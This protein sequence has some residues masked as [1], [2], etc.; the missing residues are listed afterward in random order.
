M[1]DVRA[2]YDAEDKIQKTFQGRDDTER[3]SRRNMDC[4]LTTRKRFPDT[5]S[6]LTEYTSLDLS[7]RR[8]RND[9]S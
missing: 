1:N 4:H 3:M 5:G 6:I 8:N 7:Q 2:I 9:I